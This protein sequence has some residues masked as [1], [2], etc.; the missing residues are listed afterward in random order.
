MLPVFLLR[1][2]LFLAEA[3][4][5]LRVG[6]TLGQKVTL[7]SAILLELLPLFHVRHLRVVFCGDCLALELRL[8][9]LCHSLLRVLL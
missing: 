8:F 9:Y 7:Q 4:S 1:G 3:S 6:Q 5:V 2:R